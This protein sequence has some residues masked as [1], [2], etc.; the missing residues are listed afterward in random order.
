[1]TVAKDRLK[2]KDHPEFDAIVPHLPAVMSAPDLVGRHP[3]DG[4]F[5]FVKRVDGLPGNFVGALVSIRNQRTKAGHYDIKSAYGVTEETLTKWAEV[6]RTKP[7][8]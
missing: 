8:K 7:V 5:S 4:S 2:A 3:V 6:G 1:M